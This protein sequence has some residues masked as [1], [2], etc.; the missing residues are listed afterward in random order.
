MTST[1]R[2]AARST[3]RDLAQIAVFAAL[4]AALSLPGAI[5]TGIPGVPITLQTLGVM[6]AGAVLGARNGSLAVTLYVALALIGL[7]VLPGGRGGI[8]VLLG[9][10][11]GYLIGFI[12]GAFV[13]GWATARLLPKYP[14]WSALGWTA[15]GG[16]VA[17]YLVGVPW[18]AVA[19]GIPLPAA[20]LGVLVFLPGDV[21]KV[22]VTVLVARAVHRAWPSLVAP[23]PWP[24]ARRAAASAPAADAGADDAERSRA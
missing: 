13:I 12:L 7:P 22:V 9:P 15:L 2:S 11:G 18:T 14:I 6:L 23:R 16:I 3:A 1:T 8:A 5:P 4:I 20:A 10:S 17:I 24:W 21:L 19:A